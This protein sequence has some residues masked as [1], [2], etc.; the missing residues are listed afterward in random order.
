MQ[1]NILKILINKNNLLKMIII[2]FTL[3]IV[4][5]GLSMGI[6]ALRLA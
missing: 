1:N 2:I 4:V 6:P 3:L 5:H